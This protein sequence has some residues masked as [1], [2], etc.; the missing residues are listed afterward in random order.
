M[1]TIAYSFPFVFI[2]DI[3]LLI[4]ERNAEEKLIDF[5]RNYTGKKYVLV[6][7][8]A[9][10]ALYL[11]YKAIGKEGQNIITSPIT[12]TSAISPAVEAG[13]ELNF[14]DIKN[15]TFLMDEDQISSQINKNTIAIQATHLGGLMCDMQK[16]IKIANE[17]NLV[18]I[19][20]CAQGF[21]AKQRGKNCGSYGTIACFSFIK[22]IFGIGGGVLL[23]DDKEIFTRANEIQ[24]SFPKSSKLLS[25]YRILRAV[26]ETYRDNSIISYIHRLLLTSRNKSKKNTERSEKEELQRMLKTPNFLEKRLASRQIRTKAIKML[27]K[28]I[29]VAEE[30]KEYLLLQ[31]P[32]TLQFQKIEREDDRISYVKL[33]LYIKGFDSKKNIELLQKEFAIEARHL[34]NKSSSS[35]QE[36]LSY[37]PMFKK[38][39]STIPNFDACMNIHEDI[40]SLPIHERLS[41]DDFE[42]IAKALRKIIGNE[43]IN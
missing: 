43:S 36:N 32:Q 11:S 27:E 14:V 12:C 41:K 2:K 17:H 25:L 29:V 28:R 3:F 30:L 33:Y 13:Y 42:T 4:F 7:G 6:T 39:T 1:K 9:R 16:V 5:F 18:T 22:N 37:I 26:L 34:E 24:K 10:S 23:T 21:G 19:E 35:F 15:S 31:F 8:S 20:D 38:F 40:L